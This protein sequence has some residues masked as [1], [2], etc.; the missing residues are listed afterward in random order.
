MGPHSVENVAKALTI[1]MDNEGI[2]LSKRRITLSTSGIVPVM[3]R[4]GEELGVN[5]AVSL[6]AVRDE[7]RDVLVPI[8]RKHPISELLDACPPIRVPTMLDALH[9][10]M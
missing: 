5:L 4:C 3:Q 9:L 10:S 1:I 8:N 7:L 6:H 2:A